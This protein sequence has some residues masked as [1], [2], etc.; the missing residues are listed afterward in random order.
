L[1]PKRFSDFA[2]EQAP[3]DGAKMKI[4][5]I[6]NKEISVTGFKIRV[7]KFTDGSRRCLTLQFDLNSQKYVVFSGSSILIEQMEKYGPE[8]P[9]TAT[10]KKIDRYYTLS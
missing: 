10:I 3:L 8:M 4:D 6:I 2:E 5:S 7:S 9:F 1:Q